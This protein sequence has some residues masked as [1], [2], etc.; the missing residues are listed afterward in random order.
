[1]DTAG[2]AKPSLPGVLLQHAKDWSKD[3]DHGAERF[4]SALSQ[5]GY[6]SV[7]SPVRGLQ[8]PGVI[9]AEE[10]VTP[11]HMLQAMPL[12]LLLRVASKATLYEQSS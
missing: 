10:E 5:L 7:T 2:Y 1:M 6:D 8:M 9:G 3:A 11:F 12:S 4:N